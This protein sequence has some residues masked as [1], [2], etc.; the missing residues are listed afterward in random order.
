MLASSRGEATQLTV[1]VRRLSN[2]LHARVVADRIVSRIHQDNLEVLVSQVLV[3]PVRVQHT[4]VSALAAHTLL[5]DGTQVTGRLLLVDTLVLGLSVDD[6]LA[7][8]P[9]ASSTAYGDA[10]NDESLFGLVAE[11]VCLLRAKG[12]VDPVNFRELAVLPSADTQQKAHGVRLLLAPEF[13]NV[14]VSSHFCKV[15][16]SSAFEF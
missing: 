12:A 2:P 16:L 8:W 6:T 7:V 5:S 10:V 15:C 13:F 11:S 3:N 1:P 4:E 14:S 9:L